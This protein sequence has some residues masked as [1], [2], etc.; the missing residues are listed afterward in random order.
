MGTKSLQDEAA[1]IIDCAARI[2]DRY[3][4]CWEFGDCSTISARM[5]IDISFLST[6]TRIEA[7]GQG[8]FL[9]G[10]SAKGI[11]THGATFE[12]CRGYERFSLF[13]GGLR[14]FRCAGVSLLSPIFPRSP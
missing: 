11:L 12:P 14:D 13:S 8:D 7:G 2:S 5:Q 9:R 10:N 3:L 6:G 1:A 4:P